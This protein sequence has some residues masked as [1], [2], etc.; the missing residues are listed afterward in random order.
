MNTSQIATKIKELSTRRDALAAQLKA[1]GDQ[2]DTERGKLGAALLDD[3]PA[4]AFKKEIS[5]LEIQEAGLIAALTSAEERLTVLGDSLRAVKIEEGRATIEKRFPSLYSEYRR[6]MDELKACIDRIGKM[7]DET[8][9]LYQ[10]GKQAGLEQY[11]AITRA[12]YALCQGWGGTQSADSMI[13]VK[14]IAQAMDFLTP[15][16][17][18]DALHPAEGNE[19]ILTR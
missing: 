2:L 4:G 6:N 5:R 10:L 19:A 8:L 3:Q 13:L 12:L 1:L 9:E 18:E 11:N 16:Q 17:V 14:R 7:N 15:Q